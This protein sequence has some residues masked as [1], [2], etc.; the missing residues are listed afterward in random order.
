MVDLELEAA[1]RHE[2]DG[3]VLF[4]VG[5]RSGVGEVSSEAEESRVRE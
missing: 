2:N 3:I 1:V 5:S 4:S